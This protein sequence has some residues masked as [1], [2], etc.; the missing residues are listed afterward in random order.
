MKL[1]NKQRG[2]SL[3]YVALEYF[4]A[5]GIVLDQDYVVEIG[6]RG[7]KPKKHRFDLGCNNVLVEC[8]NHTWTHGHRSNVPSAKMSVWN[9]AMFY[10]SLA[11]KS[12][13]KYFFA[14]KSSRI[15]TDELLIQYY[16]RTYYHLIP[17]DVHFMEW[18]PVTNEI[19]ELE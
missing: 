5:K 16:L 2:D 15:G 14:P 1:T 11:P 4:N 3:E 7:N 8:K 6:L 10:F 19:K 9:E 13:R 17:D 12:Y 18:N